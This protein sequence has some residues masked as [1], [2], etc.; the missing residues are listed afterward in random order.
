[1]EYLLHEFYVAHINV[2]GC[3]FWLKDLPYFGMLAAFTRE[4]ISREIFTVG[5]SIEEC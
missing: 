2:K 4:T 1:M 3:I 5:S